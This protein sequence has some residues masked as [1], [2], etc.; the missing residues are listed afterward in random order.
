[1]ASFVLVHGAWHGAWCFE[2]LT[3]YLTAMGHRAVAVE[4]PCDRPG[5][6]CSDYAEQVAREIEGLENE[7]VVVGHSF[8]GLT[9]PLIADRRP[10]GKL[11]YIAALVPKPGLSMTEQFESGEKAIVSD[12]GRELSED[13]SQSYWTDRAAAIEAMYHDC[14]PQDAEWAWSNLRPQSRAAQNEVCPLD[15]LPDVPSAYI[16]CRD[17]RLASTEWG[18]RTARE[19]LGAEVLEIDGGHSPFLSRPGELAEVLRGLI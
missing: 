18:R 17:D 7:A 10:V 12:Q 6:T 19:R 3:P 5:T 4:L 13:G 15:E 14:A 1:M 2:Q 8:A 16:V 11:V 9:L